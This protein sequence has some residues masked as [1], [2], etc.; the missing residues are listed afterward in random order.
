MALFKAP[1]RLSPPLFSKQT[2]FSNET[3]RKFSRRSFSRI[4]SVSLC[5]YVCRMSTR[6]EYDD[7]PCQQ[8]IHSS[9]GFPLGRF[10]DN[11]QSG[12]ATRYFFCSKHLPLLP[13]LLASKRHV[14]YCACVCSVPSPPRRCLPTRSLVPGRRAA[15]PATAA[16]FS[17][18]LLP[19]VRAM[20]L[21]I[22]TRFRPGAWGGSGAKLM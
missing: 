2:E 18:E 17:P 1:A 7:Q 15:V 16:V 6:Q 13:F 11:L 14:A 20:T 9:S 12:R 21:L 19:K 10:R 5:M 4:F 3:Y 8:L 22:Y